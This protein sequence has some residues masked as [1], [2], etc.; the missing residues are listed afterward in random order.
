[1]NIS[2]YIKDIHDFP[3]EGIVFKDISPLLA[4]PQALKQVINSIT[5]RY[6]SNKLDKIVGLDARGFIFGSVV[7]YALD[8]PFVMVRKPGKLPYECI[9]IDYDLEYGT[10]TFELH[11]NA[12]A[13]NDNVLIVDDLLATGGSVQ[14]VIKLIQELDANVVALECIIELGFLNARS[15]LGIDINAQITYD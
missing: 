12:I 1:M 9:S 3:K 4:N 7:A 5:S 15:L 14:A 11:K 2:N 8:V 13:K 6:T 10:N